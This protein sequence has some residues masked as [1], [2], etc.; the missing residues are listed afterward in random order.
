MLVLGSCGNK[1]PDVEQ[2]PP[3]EIQFIAP[4]GKKISAN[5]VLRLKGELKAAMQKSGV[6]EAI[7]ICNIEALQITDSVALESSFNISIK[8]T[9]NKVRNPKNAPDAYEKLALDLFLELENNKD[10]LPE[11]YIQK[12]T[13]D[14]VVHYNFYKPMMMDNLC[15]ICHG[16]ENMRAPSASRLISEL[17]PDDQ[18]I[19]YKEGDFRGLIRIKFY[20]P[21]L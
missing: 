14:D 9:S 7:S 2:P 17:Y 11:F 18:A 4:I 3:E 8:R 20:E 6:E 5:L 10:D 13:E 21:E 12:I 19:G 15:L 1:K 16:D